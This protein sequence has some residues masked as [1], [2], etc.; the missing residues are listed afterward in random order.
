GLDTADVADRLAD[1]GIA[2]WTIHLKT[3]IGRDDHEFAEA[4]YTALSTVPDIGSFYYPIEAGNVDDFGTALAAM[5]RQLTAQVAAAAQGFQPLQSRPAIDI[6]DDGSELSAFQ[7][8]VARLGYALRMDY[9]QQT[10]EDGGAPAL[11]DAWMIDRDLTDPAE[12]SID[13]RVLLTR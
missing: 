12:R 9:L 13:V 2:A 6:A 4:E 11:F 5:M 7:Q 10:A 8:K 3:E 1:L